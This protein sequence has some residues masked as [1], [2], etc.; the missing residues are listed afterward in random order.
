M[1]KVRVGR[2]PGKQST[3]TS[4]YLVVEAVVDGVDGVNGGVEKGPAATPVL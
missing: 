3:I 2:R 4:L 1:G